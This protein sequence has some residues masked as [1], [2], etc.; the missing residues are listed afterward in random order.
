MAPGKLPAPGTEYGPCEG[1]CKHLD[2]KETRSMARTTCRHCHR[3]IGYDR[4]FFVLDQKGVAKVL[5]HADCHEK[6]LALPK[7]V[8]LILTPEDRL[9]HMAWCKSHDEAFP[10][11]VDSDPMPLR[12]YENVGDIA[13]VNMWTYH[14]ADGYQSLHRDTPLWVIELAERRK[15]TSRLGPQRWSPELH[16]LKSSGVMIVRD[17]ETGQIESVV[18]NDE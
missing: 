17:P 10:I 1:K 9:K 2:C 16:N 13:S 8:A 15:W 3:E 6:N 11:P 5:A 18:V 7:R 4:L 12:H 14:D